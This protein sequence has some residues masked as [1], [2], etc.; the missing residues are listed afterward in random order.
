MPVIAAEGLRKRFGETTAVDGLSFSVTAGSILGLLGPNGAGKTTTIKLLTTLLPVDGGR[1]SVAGFDVATEADMVRRSIGLAGQNAAV[2]DKLSVRQNLDLFG[3]LY[4][5][6]GPQR[7]ARVEELV[8]RF[9]MG[10]YAD[11]LAGTLSGG[12]RRR[13]DLVAA[14]IADPP[15]IFLDEPTSGLD[16]RGRSALWDQIRAIRDDGAAVVLTTQYLEEADQLADRIVVVDRGAAVASGT[17]NELKA[18]LERDVLE[19]AVA[20]ADD[21]R[22]AL[23][24]LGADAAV[25]IDDR[26]VHLTVSSAAA[27]LAALRCLAEAGVDIADFQLRRPTLDDV[28]I[29]LTGE[30]ARDSVTTEP[31]EQS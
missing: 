20:R 26:T 6:P 27:S 15:A 22:A 28:F 23:A 10:D 5:L 1:A 16:P 17:A 21:R 14:L 9:D 25:P 8:E 24:A 3:R 12:Q 7:A 31:E 19:I 4:H 11:R 30:P 18:R 2:D 13:L 29:E